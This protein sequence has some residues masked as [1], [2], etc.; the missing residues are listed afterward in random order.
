MAGISSKALNSAPENKYRLFGK[1]MQNKEFVDGSGLEWYDY[2]MREYDQQI[3]R[4]FRVDPIIEKFYQLSPYQYCSND[5]IKNV[6]LDGAEGLHFM[7]FNKLVQNTV[8]NPNGTSAKVLGAVTGVGGAVTGI[9]NGGLHPIRALKGIGHM[10]SQSPAQNAVEYGLGLYSQYGNS[11]SDAFTTYAIGAHALTD[12]ALTLAPMKGAFASKGAIATKG[13]SVWELAQFPRGFAVED[14]RI[15]ALGEEGRL[16]AGFNVLDHFDNGVATS[17]K[18]IDLTA[19]SYNKGNGLFNTLKGYVDKLDNFT[20]GSKDG[21]TI[22]SADIS[23]RVLDVSIQ[24]GKA[25]LGQWE[26]I[27]KAMKYAKDNN[28][29]FNLQFIK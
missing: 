29:Q 11:G 13:A 24:P 6:D 16:P 25:T 1:E 12:I 26:Q 7:I 27:S 17:I 21:V 5:P 10:L 15:A 14:I 9:A 4:F 28:I 22:T 3:G 20:Y 8:Q 23:S 2:G 18:S 19:S